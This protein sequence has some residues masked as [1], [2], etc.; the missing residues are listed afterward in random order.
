MAITLDELLGRNTATV[1]KSTDTFPSYEEFSSVRGGYK[2]AERNDGYGD[3]YG[4]YSAPQRDYSTTRDYTSRGYSMRDYAD[5]RYDDT[6]YGDVVQPSTRQQNFY[7]YVARGNSSYSDADLFDRLTRPS[8]SGMRPAFGR[9][10]DIQRSTARTAQAAA[11]QPKSRGR[12]NTKGK[13]IVGSFLAVVV[14]VMSLI[15]AFAGKINAGKAVVPASNAA[16]SMASVSE[17][18]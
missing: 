6:I 13:I 14:T 2:T 10:S 12:L 3:S 4:Y 17:I 1:E 7:D 16:A 5:T 8:N 18:L 15:I 9:E 11:A